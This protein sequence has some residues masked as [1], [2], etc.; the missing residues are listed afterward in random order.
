MRK[1]FR[2]HLFYL[3]NYGHLW[4]NEENDLYHRMQAIVNAE[5]NYV[6]T[7]DWR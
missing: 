4:R 1:K 2:T 6:I 5:Y 7:S 3:F